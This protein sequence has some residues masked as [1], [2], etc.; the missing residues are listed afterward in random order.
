MIGEVVSHY[1]ILEKISDG[2]MGIVYKAEDI[3]LDRIVALKFIPHSLTGN[4]SEKKIFVNEAKAL[5]ILNH[6]NVATIYSTEEYKGKYFIVMEF[7]E[8]KDLRKILTEDEIPNLTIEKIVNII[9]QIVKGLQAAHNK[10]IVHRDIKPENIIINPEEQVKILDFG[11]A[12]MKGRELLTITGTTFGTVAY[13]SPEQSRGEY[14]DHRTDIW[15]V[16]VILYEMITRNRPF[17]GDYEQAIIYSILNETPEP[18]NSKYYNIPKKLE[19][20]VFKA[21]AKKPDDRYSNCDEFLNELKSCPMPDSLKAE[22]PEVSS[23]KHNKNFNWYFKSIIKQLKISWR[24]IVAVVILLAIGIF[25][26]YPKLSNNNLPGKKIAVLPFLNMSNNSNDEYLSDGIMEDI[27]TQLAKISDLKVISRTTMMRYKNTN[28]TIGEI[29]KD[30][31]S[32]VLLEGSVRRDSNQVRITVQLIDSKTDEHI[33]AET[34]DEKP[35]QMISIQSEI[36]LKIANTLKAEL[37]KDEKSRIENSKFN[38]PV[39]YN[40]LLKGRYFI[41]KLDSTS[42]VKA[43]ELYNEALAIEP[44]NANILTHLANAYQVQTEMGYI[45]LA[46]GYSKSRQLVEKALSIDKDLANAH[47]VLGM[48][49]VAYDWDWS[50]AGE[51]FQK[52]IKIEPGNITTLNQMGQLARTLGQFDEAINLMQRTVDLDPLIIINYLYL[53]QSQ[54]Y[55]NQL[56][57]AISTFK[58][59]LE[60]SPEFPYLHYMLASTYLLKGEPEK[61]LTE[62]EKEPIEAYRLYTLP[63]IYNDLKNKSQFE[64]ILNECIEKYQDIGSYNIAQIFAYNGNNDLAFSWLEKAYERRDGSLPYLKG[65]PFLKKIEK[66]PR[67]NKFLNKMNLPI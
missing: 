10:Q 11:L 17:R 44:N 27:L 15:S 32:D 13:M 46:A 67:Y 6:P 64:L 63:M 29:S 51:E 35:D 61:S 60:L 59:G 43:I 9:V 4:L 58:K 24:I 31:N 40:L 41:N 39:I 55:A 22:R 18:I 45:G 14:V 66:D 25:I 53:G 19:K 54:M 65:D 47:T 33:W 20:I 36:A 34:Y 21:L 2:G 28:K 5:A 26:F 49:K 52:A 30:L 42:V 8:G 48:I 38:N 7:V 57:E 37:S 3:Q 1:R 12:K 50:G 56:N 62:I 23:L 16:G